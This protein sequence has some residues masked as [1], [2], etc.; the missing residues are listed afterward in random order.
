MKILGNIGIYTSREAQSESAKQYAV[1]SYARQKSKLDRLLRKI[2]RGFLRS[3]V[4]NE[5]PVFSCL[6]APK[7]LV[8]GA[9]LDRSSRVNVEIWPEAPNTGNVT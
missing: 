4:S 1:H 9:Q 6:N 5:L 2:L 8:A 3:C 7:M